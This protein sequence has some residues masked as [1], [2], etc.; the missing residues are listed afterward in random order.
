MR[1]AKIWKT[2]LTDM[3]FQS[4]PVDR[5]QRHR[6]DAPQQVEERFVGKTKMHGSETDGCR[7]VA[8]DVQGPIPLVWY[9]S[10]VGTVTRPHQKHDPLLLAFD[11]FGSRHPK[12]KIRFQL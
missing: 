12:V 7:I 8:L 11:V 4:E 10:N 2:L 1:I 9:V 5:T 6:H 3:E